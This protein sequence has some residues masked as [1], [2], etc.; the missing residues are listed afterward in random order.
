[1]PNE[2]V[3]KVPEG[4]KSIRRGGPATP[5]RGKIVRYTSFYEAIFRVDWEEIARGTF[6]TASTFEL[7]RA[8]RPQAAPRRL[9]GCSDWLAVL[10]P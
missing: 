10:N 3:E 6:S 7:S 4:S 8:L 9:Q 1:M 5:P 2:G